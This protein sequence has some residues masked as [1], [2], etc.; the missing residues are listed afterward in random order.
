MANSGP[1]AWDNEAYCK[2][3]RR[4]EAP[5]GRVANKLTKCPSLGSSKNRLY[6]SLGCCCNSL[7]WLRHLVIL[8]LGGLVLLVPCVE[9][10]LQCAR[11]MLCPAFAGMIELKMGAIAEGV[12]VVS[13]YSILMDGN[14]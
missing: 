8:A 13:L 7:K 3:D 2:I 12:C 1:I 11:S 5:T 14:D 9:G 10:G 6:L 4:A